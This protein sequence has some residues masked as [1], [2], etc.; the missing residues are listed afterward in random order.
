MSE[1]RV[2]EFEL[3]EACI[4]LNP[5]ERMH[6]HARKKYKRRLSGDIA[7]LLRVQGIRPAS[8]T[9]MQACT[10]DVV[11]GSPNLPDWDGLYGGLK[12]LL[13]C[14]TTYHEKQRPHGLGVIL[15]DN[16]K[17][18]RRLIAQPVKT[19][20]GRPGFTHVRITEVLA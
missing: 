19:P 9:P 1:P 10:V 4:L 7:T 14:L 16:P 11:R 8:L 18:L 3:P 6:H 13:D 2:I 5:W 20:R 12:P 17:V 15:D